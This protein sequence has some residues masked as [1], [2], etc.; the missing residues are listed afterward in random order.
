[1]TTTITEATEATPATKG[2]AKATKKTKTGARSAHVTPKQAKATKKA[3][4]AKKAPTAKKDAK[5][6][7]PAT[8]EGS[9]KAEM[10]VLLQ[11]PGGATLAELMKTTGWQAHSVR[12][13]LSGTIGKKMGLKL[14]SAKNE[15]GERVYSI[16]K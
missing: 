14:S 1:M 3:T 2:S 13:F 6:V 5:A 12:G 4:P 16:T 10:L 9:R 8:R 15:A 11:R 7:K